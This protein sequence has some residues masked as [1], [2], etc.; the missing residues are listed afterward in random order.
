MLAD[1][2]KPY[3]R[4]FLACT[5]RTGWPARIE[6]AG[7]L[8]G[9]MA[10]DVRALRG[11]DLE[12]KLTATDAPSSGA[13]LDLIVYPEAVRYPAVDA[14]RWETILAEHAR[15]GRVAEDVSHEA[16]PA[17]MVL[18][19]VHAERDER[20]GR[21]G[22]PVLAA[23][24]A[25]LD[26]RGLADVALHATSHVGGHKYAGNVLVYPEGEWYGHVGPAEVPRIVERHLIEGIVVEELHRGS[27]I[28]P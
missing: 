20:C 21:C 1:S 8:L 3:H 17:R 25:E 13:G 16:A 7:G 23:F 15:A 18:V 27:M 5:G 4:H 12:P 6:E 22:P 26:R 11:T 9:R 28:T 10:S 2:V 19:C 14:G 24:R